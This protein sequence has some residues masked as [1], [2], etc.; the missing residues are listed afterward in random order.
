MT[1]NIDPTFPVEG[2]PTTESVR[3]NF[4]FAKQEIEALQNGGGETP[5]SAN[6]VLAGPPSGGQALPTY[7]LLVD[8][9]L[10]AS[11]NQ[12]FTSVNAAHTSLVNQ[13]VSL[14][15]TVS[16]N[17][18]YFYDAVNSIDGRIDDVS[19]AVSVN[20]ASIV[21]VNDVVSALGGRVAAVSARLEE[22]S[23]TTYTINRLTVV[24]GA[25]LTSVNATSL[26]VTGNVSA[27]AYYGNGSN[28]TDLPTAP[29]SVVDYTVNNLSVVTQAN[30]PGKL[31]ATSATFS[32]IVS[33]ASFVA[34]T[35]SFSTFVSTAALNVGGVVSG[36]SAVF[37]GIV[38]AASYSGSGANLT[39]VS[40]AF[41][42]SAT[43]ATNAV[44][45]TSAAYAFSATNA[46]NAEVFVGT[47]LSVVDLVVNN[48][49]VV[50]K[51]NFA[52]AI[53]GTSGVFSGV[54]SAN[55]FDAPTG[56]FSTK[57]SAAA[58]VVSGVV[59]GASAVFSAD[60]CAATFYGSGAGLTNIP[61]P[62]SANAFT[63]N[64]L[65]IVS[66]ASFTGKV[67]G[68]AAE[69]SGIVSALELDAPTGSFSTKV[70]AAALVVSGVVSGASA[71][72]S[73]NISAGAY[74]GDGSNLT[75]LPT[76]PTSVAAY[77]VNQLTV[78]SGASFLGKVSGTAAEFSGIVSALELDA[79]TGSFS[80]KVSAAALVVSGVVS[81]ASAV[82]SGNISAG[83][84]YG[85]GSNLSNLPTA[86]TSVA[87][88]TVNQ[89]TVVSGAAFQGKVSGTAAEFSGVVSALELDAPTGS[90]STLV[91]AA[92]LTV[93]GIVS[94]N[95]AVFSGVVSA[96]E[97]D[98]PTGSFSTKVSAAALVVSGVVSGASAVFSAD[99]CAATFYGSGAGLT[100]LP[101]SATSVAAF[102][103]NQ[104]TVVSGAAFTGK[105]SGTAGEFSGVVSA[106]ELDAP[107]GS[108][109]TLVSA[110]AITISGVVS[111]NSA[112]FSGVVSALEFD[113]PTGS[114]STLVSAAALN[115][116][117]VVSGNSAIFTGVV[118]ALEFDAPTGSF[119]TLV[120]A[121]AINISGVVSGN[122]AVFSGVVSALEFDAPTGSFSTKVS[123][124]AIV[125][126]GI[127]SGNSG[128]FSGTV[129]VN[130]IAAPTGSFSTKVSAAALVISG[131]T[132]GNSGVFSGIVSANEFDAPTGSFSTIVSAAAINVT[133]PVSGT[134]AIFT[135]VVS[136]LEF[137][138]P[139]GSFSTIV[140]AAAL[141]VSGI[142]SGSTAVFSGIVSVGGNLFDNIGNIRT[143]P[144]NSQTTKYTASV[145]DNGRFITITTG[146]VVIPSGVFSA[147]QNFTIYND[148]TSA[149]DVSSAAGVTTYLVGTATTGL[150]TIAQRGLATVFCV[151]ANSFVITGGGLA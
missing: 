129:S 84:Y 109:S 142:V 8:A 121:A 114:F 116:S 124:A 99:V 98:A 96:L 47:A 112:V 40:A 147:G 9:D 25:A 45:A 91:S 30:I 1:S 127:T 117:G 36:S 78:V 26:L 41:A 100:N 39:N 3:R 62:T 111:G 110:A 52:A 88:Y 89:L 10:P 55:E 53:S 97:F 51:A 105:V 56:S 29:T 69:F 50:T 137:D 33:A 122:S 2:Y 12:Q 136:A 7:R 144:A 4:L 141:V 18:L 72:F 28:L 107:T 54:V 149:Q 90:F 5:K 108:F 76:A 27:V 125:I 134:S 61:A 48:L 11:I 38:S 82:F 118:S 94:G 20:A 102:T 79:P 128:V 24:S 85:D 83:A 35:G 132:S 22:A 93:S 34:D 74:Y 86:P 43:N 95:S 57:V 138:A 146:G 31:N 68:T 104:L 123:A 63:I 119:S 67:S 14:S 92:A 143:V 58:L 65:T 151:S 148:S 115:V 145:G 37:S 66:G 131:I 75:N 81:G 101:P 77:T 106:L 16:A 70:S 15:G 126:S 133:G 113:A 80:T 32:A 64:Q 21:S 103:V 46:T 130:E 135:G 44:N 60:V 87:A 6:T 120:S 150:R 23:A 19:A 42:S 140:S 17:Y 139:T 73:G 13:V 71:V 59:S 49:S